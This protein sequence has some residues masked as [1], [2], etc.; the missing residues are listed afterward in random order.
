MQGGPEGGPEMGPDGGPETP[1]DLTRESVATEIKNSEWF[2]SEQAVR[3]QYLQD[4]ETVGM[5]NQSQREAYEKGI[6]EQSRNRTEDKES[7]EFSDAAMEMARTA[8][9]QGQPEVAASFLYYVKSGRTAPALHA[10]LQEKALLL[11]NGY[12]KKADNQKRRSSEL[13]GDE[14]KRYIKDVL[15]P[16][17]EAAKIYLRAA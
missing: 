2:H 4:L 11:A 7:R 6:T 13:T 8:S 10:G 15:E 9:K 14:Q 17:R 5:L 3:D 16:S 1:A 12:I